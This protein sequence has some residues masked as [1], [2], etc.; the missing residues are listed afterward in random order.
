[1][2]RHIFYQEDLY[3]F[4]EG[5]N[6]YSYRFL[7]AHL[8]EEN[9][10]RGTRFTVWAPNAEEVRLVGDFNNWQGYS[11]RM[12]QISNSQLWSIFVGN[13]QEGAL[14]KYEVYG[15][16]REVFLKSD[17]YGF[18]SELRPD[19]ASIVYH[20]E[21]YP[22]QDQQW[23]QKKIT[24]S[25]LKKPAIIYEVHLGSW[26][27]KEDGSFYNYREIAHQLGDYVIKMGYT[28]VEI[29]PIM[30]HPLDDSWGYQVT[31]YYAV[32][33][34]YGTPKDF[35]YFV[36]YM[37][38]RGIGVILDWV[39]GHF[40]KDQHGLIEFDG[41]KVYEY[42]QF[43]KATNKAWGT[44]NFDLG[45]PEVKSFIISNAF[46]WMDMYHIDGLRVDAV[47]N[48]LYL[49]YGKTEEEWTPNQYGGKENLE[50]AA[51]LKELN[52]AV[53][54]YY[55]NHLMIAEEATQW[56]MVTAS[57]YAG[58]LGFN[59]K[60]NMGWMNDTLKYMEL[61][62]KERKGHHDLLTFSLMYTFTENFI[63]PLSHDEVVH[64]K[65][66]LLE[67]MP[68]SYE[69]KF[70][71]LRCCY[72]YMMAHPGKKHLFMGGEFGQFTEWNHHSAL[73][74]MLLDYEMHAKLQSYVKD[75]IHF[76]KEEPTLWTEDHDAAGFQWID[77]NDD[78]HSII[79]F[80]RKCS[81]DYI[82]VLCN[83]SPKASTGYRIGVPNEGEY[84][85]V[86][87]SDAVQ[88]GGGGIRNLEAVKAQR[89][90]WHHQPYSIEISIPALATIYFKRI[91]NKK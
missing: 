41:G 80:M 37:H 8:I 72:G 51:F 21:N 31:G 55:P 90:P 59:Y 63:L 6:Y 43:N 68:G 91:H 17:P 84:L 48:M 15:K 61:D 70:A 13:I 53:S 28:H 83:F 52:K 82:I 81:Q 34:R 67:K 71:N 38:Q 74:W 14:Y 12:E 49:D 75:L 58:G 87:N 64:G 23:Q 36:N 47:T 35:M 4:H 7:G 27:R 44:V 40:C 62:Y 45:K 2:D 46:F 22:W 79:I 73:D 3:L 24:E 29:L 39:P 86:F 20:L 9:G 54:H 50:A 89:K 42:N 5:T 19:T 18:L 11:H 78:N 25:P 10:Q 85:E 57:T 33:S 16:N 1:M 30:E 76:Y 65:K 32:T 69:E 88:Y 66:S 56:P 77:V 26:K 60:W